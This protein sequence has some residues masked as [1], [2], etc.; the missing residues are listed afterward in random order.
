MAQDLRSFLAALEEQKDLARIGKEVGP[1]G[2]TA[3]HKEFSTPA[4]RPA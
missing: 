1:R 2:R 4:G 3:V